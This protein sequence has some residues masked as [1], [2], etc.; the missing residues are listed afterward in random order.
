VQQTGTLPAGQGWWRADLTGVLLVA[1]LLTLY[2]LVALSQ[3]GLHPD[4]AYYWIWSRVPSAGYYDHAPMI[5]WWIRFS[6]WIFGDSQLAVR[7]LPILSALVVSVATSA[8]AWTLYRDQSLAA[9]AGLWVNAAPLVGIA[10]LCATPDSPSLLF[11]TL[12]VWA[13]ACLRNGGDR[14]LW[15]LVGLLAGLGCASKYTNLFLGPGI[16]LWLLVD[17][18]AR[19]RLVGRWMFAGGAIALAV[20]SPVVWWNFHHHWVS[21]A[22]QFGRI[23][24]GGLSPAYLVEFLVGQFGLVNPAIAV[25]AL[26]GVGAIWRRRGAE[27]SAQ[28]LFLVALSAPLI[29][30]MVIHSIHSRVH[31]NWPMPVYPV[32][33]LLAADAARRVRPRGHLAH[34]ARWAGPGGIILVAIVLGYFALPPGQAAPFASPADKLIGWKTMSD[35]IEVLRQRHHAGWIATVDYGVTGALT[36]YRHDPD[37]VQEVVDRDRYSFETPDPLLVSQPALLVVPATGSL[38]DWL[39]RCLPRATS[40]GEVARD[41]GK[42]EIERFSV[43]KIEQIPPDILV[44]GCSRP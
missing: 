13:L 36:F 26:L 34:A 10:G 15:L 14:R 3:I 24:Q 28:T 31:A 12:A 33:A 23:D 17:G 18:D 29:V 4:E 42:R 38:P 6:T 20:F 37:H 40:V 41:A 35:E 25:L 32:I 21:F 27:G 8:I 11:W 2:R 43:F 16:L 7:S 19:R 9:R 22:K 5:A 39:G 30:Y 1:V 44:Q